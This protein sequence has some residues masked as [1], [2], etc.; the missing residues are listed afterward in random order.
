MTAAVANDRIAQGAV[1]WAN[2]NCIYV[3]GGHHMIGRRLR[4]VEKLVYSYAL[5]K[6]LADQGG[7]YL[8]CFWP[9]AISVLPRDK[10]FL[11]VNGVQKGVAQKFEL[12]IPLHSLKAVLNQAKGR[13]YI[14]QSHTEYRLTESGLQYLDSLETDKDVER[15]INALFDDMRQFLS[16]RLGTT[17]SV[18]Q[19]SQ[20]LF[21]F[22]HK[23]IE[24]LIQ[25]FS[26]SSVSIES[27]V[28][29]KGMTS[30]G[31]YLIEY[32]EAAEERKPEHHK[33]LQDI[34]FG[35]V[36]STVLNSED[37]S[38]MIEI[39]TRRFKHCQVFLDTNFVFS[40][41]GLHA[42]EFNEPAKELFEL[43]KQRRFEIKVF[44]FTVKE[45]CKVINGYLEEEY[46][47]P[48]SIMV[49][50]LYSSLKR[51][52]WTKTDAREFIT[53][54]EDKLSN[55]G[56]KVEWV[57]EINLD[58]YNQASNELRSLM[59]SP[60]YKPLQQ[61]F[62][63][64]HDIVAMEKIAEIRGHP[65]RKIETSKAIFLTSDKRLCRFN[66]EQMGHQKDG[67]ICEVI[68]DSLLT[69][70][71]WLKDPRAGISLK[72]MIAAYSRD[73][74][75]KRRI[76]ERFYEALRKLKQEERV[77]D[78][79]IS[80]LFYHNYIEE[81]L[82]ELDE[83]QIDDITPEFVLE[84]IEEAAKLREEV[85]QRREKEFIQHLGEE[86]SK[87]EERK[88]REWLQKVQEFKN[89][90]RG[91]ARKSSTRRS[92]TYAS[93]L[94]LLLLGMMYGVYLGFKEL[95]IS[96]VLSLLIPLA[97]GGSGIGGI[98]SKLRKFFRSKLSDSIYLKKLK[99]I[100]L[101][102]SER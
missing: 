32:L 34:F 35:S 25:F 8:D 66:F 71:L 63:Q 28:S 67:T 9:F 72:S 29:Q 88:N 59:A 73:L 14:E 19:I 102:E 95:G 56:I 11:D 98:W 53:N 17:M 79:A 99:E 75:V 77:D 42:F 68:L 39:R 22:V 38:K 96:D 51:I 48:T 50:T 97:I 30:F 7:D 20:A 16:E 100:G 15:R 61:P 46:R 2:L 10:K 60:R 49:D 5:I 23:N 33:T 18:D 52:G 24:P 36:I 27:L 57:K 65:V 6:S 41:L 37:P 45:I 44:E 92:S 1:D 4:I 85:E 13:K 40:I 83:T 3:L 86:V 31:K 62:H 47:Y 94:T 101:P 12:N 90:I 87:V 21:S 93:L 91:A 64:N 26:P 43:L 74:F 80:M 58:D 54:I 55:L 89:N 84:E 76:W 70:I 69:N 78:E 82:R 81:S